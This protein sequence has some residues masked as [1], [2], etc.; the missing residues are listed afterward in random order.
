MH[1]NSHNVQWCGT[2]WF[3]L[4]V[5]PSPSA[6]TS[7]CKEPAPCFYVACLPMP[8]TSPR[9]V[10]SQALSLSSRTCCG[11]GS[12][13]YNAVIHQHNFAFQ[14]SGNWQS[15]FR[16]L[17]TINLS[18][19]CEIWPVNSSGLWPHNRE[20]Y[21]HTAQRSDLARQQFRALAAQQGAIRAR[22]PAIF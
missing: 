3:T 16:L 15:C 18:L 17:S 1:Q 4:L 20:R 11:F 5:Y 10:H 7:C 12:W 19:R 14:R 8:I 6:W 2:S 22:S 21:G 13:F 9:G